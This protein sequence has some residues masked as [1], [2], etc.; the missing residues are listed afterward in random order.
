MCDN[1]DKN[2]WEA[3]IDPAIVRIILDQVVD[4]GVKRLVRE[5]P[6]LAKA[7][8]EDLEKFVKGVESQRA[9]RKQAVESNL[10][11][12]DFDVSRLKNLPEDKLRGLLQ[13]KLVP[14]IIEDMKK[15]E[16]ERPIP[17]W[18]YAFF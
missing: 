7:P 3:L 9:A 4:G 8:P 18:C 17:D 13:N 1:P 15:L 12:I 5:F 10:A 14:R 2:P 11:H 16:V 6:A